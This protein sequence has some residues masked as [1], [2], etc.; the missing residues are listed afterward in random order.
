MLKWIKKKIHKGYYPQKCK[1]ERHISKIITPTLQRIAILNKDAPC[2]C[3]YYKNHQ[4]FM[5]QQF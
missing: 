3:G 4:D 5:S 2:E 1:T